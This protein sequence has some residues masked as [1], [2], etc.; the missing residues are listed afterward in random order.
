MFVTELGMV[1]EVREEQPLNA[2]PPMLVTE[3]GRVTSPGA[4]ELHTNKIVFVSSAYTK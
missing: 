3:L 2:L 4:A 1:M